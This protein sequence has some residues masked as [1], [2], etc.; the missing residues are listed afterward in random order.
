VDDGEE[1]WHDEGHVQPDLLQARLLLD[2]DT[3]VGVSVDVVAYGG[4]VGG[5]ALLAV[6]EAVEAD[7]VEVVGENEEEEGRVDEEDQAIVEERALGELPQ[8]LSHLAAV[9]K[10]HV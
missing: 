3:G 5:E 10:R 7:D 6:D 9:R 4:V 1:G 8:C 2:A